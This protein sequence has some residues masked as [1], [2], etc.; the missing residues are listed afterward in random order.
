MINHNYIIF[1]P[2]AVNNLDYLE[3]NNKFPPN[4]YWIYTN[5]KHKQIAVLFK[6]W[7]ESC[8]NILLK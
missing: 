8:D 2:L 6:K 1:L 4:N 5:K 3:Q 7:V